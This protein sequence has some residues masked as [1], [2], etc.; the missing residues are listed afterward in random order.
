MNESE[1][2]LSLFRKSLSCFDGVNE[3]T[4]ENSFHHPK[5]GKLSF[6]L[7]VEELQILCGEKLFALVLIVEKSKQSFCRERLFVCSADEIIFNLNESIK[8]IK[9]IT[10]KLNDCYRMLFDYP[11]TSF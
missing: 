5:F 2:I 3:V 4:T 7:K 6:V 10:L 11:R 9:S 8:D 1:T